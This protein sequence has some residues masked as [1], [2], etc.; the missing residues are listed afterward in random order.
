MKRRE[1]PHSR[2]TSKDDAPDWWIN[3]HN[4]SLR[5]GTG[6]ILV[7]SDKGPEHVPMDRYPELADALT[8]S[9][10]QHA[11]QNSK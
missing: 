10:A 2:A 5:Y 6:V 8:T 11:Q 9:H 1:G 3:A 7:H 4:D